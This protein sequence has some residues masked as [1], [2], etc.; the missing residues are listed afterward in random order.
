[1][2]KETLEGDQRC[3]EEFIR[4]YR[5]YQEEKDKK[6]GKNLYEIILVHVVAPS[7]NL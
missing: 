3:R 2:A 5:K 7:M 4:W 6:E 1:M